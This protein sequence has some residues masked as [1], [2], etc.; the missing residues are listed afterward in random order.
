MGGFAPKTP[1]RSVTPLD[2][3][4]VTGS[5]GRSI[6]WVQGKALVGDRGQSPQPSAFR[7]S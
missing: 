6:W 4:D 3:H 1:T 2:P 5:K 7:R